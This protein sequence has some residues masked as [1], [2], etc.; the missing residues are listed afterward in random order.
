MLVI[1]LVAL[2]VYIAPN[3]A[4][5]TKS[6]TAGSICKTTSWP[7]HETSSRPGVGNAQVGVSTS[8]PV[9]LVLRVWSQLNSTQRASTDAGVKHLDVRIY[10]II[11]M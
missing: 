11:N 3:Q 1:Q 10:L 5:R 2:Y 4:I 7:V 9:T 8:C 6:T